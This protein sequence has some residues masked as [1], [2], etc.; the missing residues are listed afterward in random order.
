MPTRE[1]VA[2]RGKG[3]IQHAVRLS[4]QG[5]RYG[6]EEGGDFPMARSCPG[7]ARATDKTGSQNIVAILFQYTAVIIRAPL[8]YL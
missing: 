5:T 6:G 3:V 2:H 4:P 8:Y 1:L 7:C